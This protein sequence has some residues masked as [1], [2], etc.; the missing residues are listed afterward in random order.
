MDDDSKDD[1][2]CW[3]LLFIRAGF[4]ALAC[5]MWVGMFS[6][7]FSSHGQSAGELHGAYVRLPFGLFD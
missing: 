5:A 3:K 2:I 7:L 4:V 6:A 1:K